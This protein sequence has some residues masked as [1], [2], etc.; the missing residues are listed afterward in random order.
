MIK[1]RRFHKQTKISN[2]TADSEYTRPHK[3]ER[4]L[5][6]QNDENNRIDSLLASQTEP[7]QQALL[8]EVKDI[9]RKFHE[10]KI[11]YINLKDDVEKLEIFIRSF[12]NSYERT[13]S[14]M[15]KNHTVFMTIII[16]IY[17]ISEL[18]QTGY[19]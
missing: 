4:K 5:S 6:M 16:V 7:Q 15:L 14:K 9:A 18:K 11:K 13:Y 8:N 1:I 3:R 10:I 17:I 2:I 12:H 19:I